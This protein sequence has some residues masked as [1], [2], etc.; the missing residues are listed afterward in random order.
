MWRTGTG[1]VAAC[2][3]CGKPAS[4][5]PARRSSVTLHEHAEAVADRRPPLLQNATGGLMPAAAGASWP[6]VP[7]AP[8]A[9]SAN[10]RERAA[11]GTRSTAPPGRRGCST[12]SVRGR[13]DLRT[14]RGYWQDHA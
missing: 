4:G 1:A 11:P 14:V 7:N 6:V 8:S 13:G 10:Q 3:R 2:C 5:N 12:E 9:P